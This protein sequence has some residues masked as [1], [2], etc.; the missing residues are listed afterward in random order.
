MRKPQAAAERTEYRTALRALGQARIPFVIGGEWGVTH[1]ATVGRTTV[2]L[3]L[4]IQP[5]DVGRAVAQLVQVGA[6]ELQRD[7]IHVSLLYNVS[8]IDM[9]HHIAHGLIPVDEGWRRR[10]VPTRLFGLQT[11]VASVEDLIWSKAFIAA[12]HRFDGADIVHLIRATHDRL[13]W[14]RLRDAF[15]PFP[16][17]LLAYI[18]L[19]SFC[20]PSEANA[21]PEWLL[22]DLLS[23]NVGVSATDHAAIC[24][25]ALLDG[26]SFD[27]DFVAKGYSP[28]AGNP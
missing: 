28:I 21:V 6:R 4:M 27:F 16:Q 24:R 3:D 23:F 5:A 8:A 14:K 7:E 22:N 10:A 13:D 17:L 15:D 2:D 25:G 26:N 9:V 11:F 20:Y 18:N 12:R 1:Y 19:F